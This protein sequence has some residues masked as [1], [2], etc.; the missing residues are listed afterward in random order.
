MLK[1]ENNQFPKISVIIPTSNEAI[2]L[3]LLLS[4]LS[5]LDEDGEIII[6]DAAS[7]DKT[8]EIAN[9]YGARIYNSNKKTGVCSCM[10]EQKKPGENGLFFYMLILD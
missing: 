8:V 7:E 9:I 5:I 1:V 2:N 10:V 3:P 6:M 4:D